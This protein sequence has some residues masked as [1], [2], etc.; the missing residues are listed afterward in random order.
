MI[1]D[2]EEGLRLKCHVD[3][4]GAGLGPERCWSEWASEVEKGV[5]GGH[6][7]WLT[8]ENERSYSARVQKSLRD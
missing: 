3:R 5:G 7:G 8:S 2:G 6:A 4:G 1:E